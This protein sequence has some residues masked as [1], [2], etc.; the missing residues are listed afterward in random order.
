MDIIQGG[1]KLVAGAN[2]GDKIYIHLTTGKTEH[3]ILSEVNR[4][5]VEGF[6]TNL[7]DKTLT[8]FPFSAII[9]ITKDS[10]LG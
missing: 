2:A 8:F 7:L 3:I 6:N 5:G 9:K 10:T 4:Y 1:G